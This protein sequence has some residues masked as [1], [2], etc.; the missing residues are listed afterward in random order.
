MQAYG[1]TGSKRLL[2]ELER[3]IRLRGS[4]GKGTVISVAGGKG[5]RSRVTEIVIT[6]FD[7]NVHDEQTRES[8][9]PYEDKQDTREESSSER[10]RKAA[11]LISRWYKKQRKQRLAAEDIQE[12]LSKLEKLLEDSVEEKPIE[13]LDLFGKNYCDAEM[14]TDPIDLLQI[15]VH[16][17]IYL[18]LV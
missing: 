1:T 15:I 4:A 8:S 7:T 3:S 18:E 12:E 13:E 9:I 10:Q 11:L 2:A 6:E 5:K 14:Q 16:H 17:V